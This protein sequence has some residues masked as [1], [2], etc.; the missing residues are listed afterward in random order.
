[1]LF[2]MYKYIYIVI[3]TTIQSTHLLPFRQRL[4]YLSFSIEGI[5]IRKCRQVIRGGSR[6]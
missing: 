1:M 2:G 6:V 3:H 5:A 4:C